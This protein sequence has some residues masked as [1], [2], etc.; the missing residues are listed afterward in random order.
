MLRSEPKMPGWRFRLLLAAAAV[1][2]CVA[3]LLSSGGERTAS[4]LTEPALQ[5]ASAELEVDGDKAILVA[6]RL[7]PPPP[8]EVYMVWLKRP[9][10]EA[11]EPTSALFT[12]RGD[13]SATASV[14]GVD[15]AE[16]VL[17][18]TEQSPD[19]TQP[20]SSVLM[21]ATLS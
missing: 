19:V 1:L 16:A 13:G 12:P 15:D 2:A 14:T 4:F 7:P 5:Q 10:V 17:V 3:L 9:G 11:P 18:N 8:G 21:S 20:T 6:N